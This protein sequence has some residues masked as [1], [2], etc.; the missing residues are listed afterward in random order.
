MQEIRN[1]AGDPVSNEINDSKERQGGDASRDFA[2][3]SLPVGDGNAGE[4]S[5]LTYFRRYETGHI[6]STVGILEEGVFGLAAEADVS[7]ASGLLVAANDFKGK[8]QSA[9]QGSQSL[10]ALWGSHLEY[11][12]SG[13]IN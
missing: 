3:D 13:I 5:E 11:V 10:G 2:G 4:S 1:I 7:N 9:N 12:I 8:Y 6:T